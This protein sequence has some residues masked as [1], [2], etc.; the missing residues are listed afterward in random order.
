LCS[1]LGFTSNEQQRKR[2]SA[3]GFSQKNAHSA[4]TWAAS[5]PKRHFSLA[6]HHF[7]ARG[8]KLEARAADF[9]PCCFGT[10]ARKTH[11]CAAR[12]TLPMVSPVWHNGSQLLERVERRFRWQAQKAVSLP[13]FSVRGENQ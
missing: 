1:E 3:R 9:A 6:D 2:H 11:E 12:V 5:A 10:T 8:D 7:S 4:A 13:N